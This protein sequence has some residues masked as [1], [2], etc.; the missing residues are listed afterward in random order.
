MTTVI[1]TMKTAKS[2]SVTL[3]VS[4]HAAFRADFPF[5]L[6]DAAR[7]SFTV[8]AKSAKAVYAWINKNA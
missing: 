2:F 1:S 8:P 7:S 4:M 5:A 6:A 3:P